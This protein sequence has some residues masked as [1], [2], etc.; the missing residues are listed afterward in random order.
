MS[1]MF[2]KVF[3]VSMECKWNGCCAVSSGTVFSGRNGFDLSKVIDGLSK[4][5]P[6]I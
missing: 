2:F 3:Q 1:T 4:S 6:A 5:I